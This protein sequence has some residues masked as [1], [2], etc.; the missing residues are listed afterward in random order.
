VGNVRY[1]VCGRHRRRP[2]LDWS[3]P[4]RKTEMRYPTRASERVHRRLRPRLRPCPPIR[5]AA[6]CATARWRSPKALE[7]IIREG[8]DA[9]PA[10]S[11]AGGKTPPRP[12]RRPQHHQRAA[13]PGPTGPI[14]SAPLN[15]AVRRGGVRAGL[16]GQP[17]PCP[18]AGSSV[19]RGKTKALRPLAAS[20]EAPVRA[21]FNRVPLAGLRRPGSIPVD[22]ASVDRHPNGP[23]RA[24]SDSAAHQRRRA[25]SC[26]RCETP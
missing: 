3:S 12:A 23:R 4:G 24:K 14:K 25:R 20:Q 1:P 9:H 18:P 17:P 11:S 5:I 15:P 13:L 2:T 16:G 10:S 19:R 6:V 26:Q 21:P 22:P 8:S 7:S